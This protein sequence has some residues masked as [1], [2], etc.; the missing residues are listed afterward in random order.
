MPPSP[1]T[2]D[3]TV[4][5]VDGAGQACVAVALDGRIT[6]VHPV[7]RW[8]RYRYADLTSLTD[9]HDAL[10]V[11]GFTP[12]EIG[13]RTVATPSPA[14]AHLLGDTAT[15][16]D[17]MTAY[18]ALARLYAGG[19]CL[20]VHCDAGPADALRIWR[21]DD[22]GVA[23]VSTTPAPDGEASVSAYCRANGLAHLAASHIEALA[24][25]GR[26][27][28]AERPSARA[29]PVSS[30]RRVPNSG[31]AAALAAAAQALSTA[32]VDALA[33]TMA[34][35]DYPVVLAGRLFRSSF[36]ATA[37]GRATDRQCIVPPDPGGG[38]LAIGTLAALGRVREIPSPFAGP[39]FS[40]A[41]AKLALERCKLHY[42]YPSERETSALVVDALQRG[43]LVAW[44][45]G[46]ME[47]GP[48][49]LGHRSILADATNPYVLENLNVY[50]K[51]RPPYM[52][53]ALS[54]VGSRASHVMADSRES[55]TMQFESPLL[56]PDLPSFV[57]HPSQP[58]RFQTVDEQP[59]GL[60][61]LLEAFEAA[62]G[63]PYLV[64]TSF[65]A[66]TEP[67]VAN[68]YD[69]IR[70]FFGSGLDVLIMN[71]FV[72]VK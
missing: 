15:L 60:Y 16:V 41:D 55:A 64:N 10:A 39:T 65:N 62:T 28:R 61:R 49:A 72:V 44:F 20:L 18:Q 19:P 25:A 54:V 11:A 63:T 38:G 31:D 13:T 30:E 35:P 14:L 71:G 24:R 6:L 26:P 69:A 59:T 32:A 66:V 21:L 23:P 50:L 37:L 56:K 70:C 58:V 68:P 43:R 48:R 3:T 52:S 29:T 36:F 42:Q 2:S 4:A 22:N 40:A 17:P 34:P 57:A 53:Y 7:E 12:S 46:G 9:V 1:S 5:L 8:R 45:E 33:N 47:W 27:N 51:Q 67:I